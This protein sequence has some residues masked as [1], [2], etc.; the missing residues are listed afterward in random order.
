MIK[1]PSTFQSTFV[2][3]V[4][5]KQLFISVEVTFSLNTLLE[6]H[7]LTHV[8]SENTKHSPLYASKMNVMMC[9][10]LIINENYLNRTPLD[11]G[12]WTEQAI[13]RCSLD[14]TEAMI[15]IFMM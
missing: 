14:F 2:F 11:F 6:T 7:S 15:D 8:S 12:G 9:R 3:N 10:C 4:R 1:E 13:G 5:R